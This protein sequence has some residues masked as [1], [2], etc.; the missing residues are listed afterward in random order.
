MFYIITAI[1]FDKNVI[2]KGLDGCKALL[3]VTLKEKDELFYCFFI[4][5]LQ[6]RLI[7]ALN[8]VKLYSS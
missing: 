4:Y 5:R 8:T 1:L 2:K 6:V 3:I 7:N